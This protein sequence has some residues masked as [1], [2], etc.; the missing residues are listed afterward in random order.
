M[1]WAPTVERRGP[2]DEGW[3]GVR[4]TSLDRAYCHRAAPDHT[5]RP[6]VSRAWTALRRVPWWVWLI[7]SIALTIRLIVVPYGLPYEF[8]ADERSFVGAAWQA[9]ANGRGDPG[10]YAN[11]ASLLLDVL[12]LLYATYGLVGM[13][14]GAF[15]S[16]PEVTEAYFADVSHFFIIGRVVTAVS[17]VAVVIMTYVVAR[18]LHV[19]AFWA[20]TAA[21]LIALSGAMIQFSSVV[22][23]DMLTSAFLLATVVA[24]LNAIDWPSA[25]AFIVGGVCLGLAVTSKWPGALAVV[26]LI[27]A[28]ATLVIERRITQRRGLLWLGGATLAALVIAAVV[29]PYL[30]VNWADT[31][32]A[33]RTE[34]RTSELGASGQ[35]LP[36]NL[37]R[38]LTEALPWGLGVPATVIGVAGTAVMLG[39]RRPRAVALTFWL[40]LLFI[41]FLSLWWLRWALPLMPLLAIAA[42]F[43]LTEADR[44]MVELRPGPWIG[45]ARLA[46]AAVMVLPLVPPTLETVAAQAT[47]ADTRI[48]A[49]EW[50]EANVPVGTAILIDSSTTQLRSDRYDVHIVYGGELL[51]WSRLHRK[52]RPEG[53]FGIIATEWR[54]AP[55]ALISRIEEAGIRYVVLGDSWI[56]LV[57]TQASTSPHLLATYEALV[58]RYPTIERFDRADAATGPALSILTVRH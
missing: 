28:N 34:N 9:V 40:F 33:L 53:Y 7:T 23:A 51:P 25:R 20:A 11:P 58:E 56:D 52:V 3:R 35:G 26:P 49:V 12:G 10:W 2:V 1:V 17:G 38:Y 54:D 27:V 41:S 37:W 55:E 47:N 6:M 30:I 32:D 15:D 44:R 13:L 4:A 29:G 24:S 36:V 57:R 42:A 31:I 48:R 19:T 14:G 39:M 16:I 46:I 18:R 5:V 8:D 50:I 21:L 43:V 22:R 45:S